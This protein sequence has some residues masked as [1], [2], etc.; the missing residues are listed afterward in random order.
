LLLTLIQPTRN[1]DDEKRKWIQTG[2]HRRS[3]SHASSGSIVSQGGESSFWTLRHH[4]YGFE[5][6]AA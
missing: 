6:A 3:L 4:E 5:R 1:G 2:S